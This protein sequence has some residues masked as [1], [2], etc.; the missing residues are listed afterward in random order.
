MRVGSLVYAT[1]QGLGMLGKSFY[2]AGVINDVMIV[3]HPSRSIQR[4]DWYPADTPTVS[5]RSAKGP[6]V[7]KF[8][9]KINVLLQF[10]TAFD[11]TLL[12]RCRQ[13]GVKTVLIPMY[14]WYPTKPPAQFDYFINPSLLDQEYFPHGTFIPIPVTGIP[15]NQRTRARK[16]VHNAGH[17][18][19]R[20]H[21]GTFEVLRSTRFL[22]SDAQLTVRSQQDG[23]LR[24]LI[25][26]S[27]ADPSR[28]TIE[29]GGQPYETLWTGYDA[30]VVPEKY[31]GLSLPL[32]EARAAGMLVMASDRFPANTWLPKEPLIPVQEYRRAQTQAGHLM[33]DEACVNSAVIANKIDEWYDKDITE[34]SLS[35]KQW[36]DDHSWDRL[37]SRY[38]DVLERVCQS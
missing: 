31:N 7:D 19:S 33:F 22:K 4:P 17:I 34:Y 27:E 15:W 6:E 1:E 24:K 13:R 21:K 10:E 11:W 8:L 32:Q 36:A 18:G 5:R 30:M 9:A 38:T 28:V 37:K 25:V 12:N 2:D 3:N 14:E 20:E 16:F 35:G 26:S 23:K 29:T